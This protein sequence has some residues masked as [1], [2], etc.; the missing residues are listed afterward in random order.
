[1]TTHEKGLWLVK[2]GALFILLGQ[3]PNEKQF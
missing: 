2:I 3:I 1:M